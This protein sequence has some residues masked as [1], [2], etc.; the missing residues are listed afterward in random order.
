MGIMAQQDKELKLKEKKDALKAIVA[1]LEPKPAVP[2]TQVKDESLNVKDAES[3]SKEV[4]D[5]TK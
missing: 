1:N 4:A 3:M 2:K 5:L